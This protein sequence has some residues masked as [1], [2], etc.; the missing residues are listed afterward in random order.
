MP[1]PDEFVPVEIPAE[2]LYEEVPDYQRLA[3]KSG[4]EGIVWVKALVDKDGNVK[5]AM[6]LKSSGSRAG[7]DEAAVKAAYKCKFK[8]AIQ[9]HKPVA[10]WVSY[11]VEF[12]LTDAGH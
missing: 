1:S 3:K 9:N 6:V 12:V 11:S 8:P 10:V 4:M 2:M 5:K 7:F